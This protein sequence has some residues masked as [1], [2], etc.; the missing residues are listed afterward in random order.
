MLQH[1]NRGGLPLRPFLEV[2]TGI[3]RIAAHLGCDPER[4]DGD[5]GGVAQGGQAEEADVAEV[6][7]EGAV[8]GDDDPVVEVVEE[9]WI[10]RGRRGT[11]RSARRERRRATP[12][13]LIERGGLHTATTRLRPRGRR[14]RRLREPGGHRAPS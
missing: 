7:L 9:R 6:R 2:E 1:G 8:V 10:G 5:L 11:R 12:H 4:V 3:D 13:N 14:R